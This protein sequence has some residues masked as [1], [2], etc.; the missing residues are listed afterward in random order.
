M[1]RLGIQ[2]RRRE[3]RRG[4]D[5]RQILFPDLF[6]FETADTAAGNHIANCLIHQI[7]PFEDKSRY[8]YTIFCLKCLIFSYFVEKC[9][10]LGYNK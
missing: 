5:F 6:R 7:S 10:I 2:R 9:G 3:L 4:E 1:E 8:D